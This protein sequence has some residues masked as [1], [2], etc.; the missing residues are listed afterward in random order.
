MAIGERYINVFPYWRHSAHTHTGWHSCGRCSNALSLQGNAFDCNPS[1]PTTVSSLPTAGADEVRPA[2]PQIGGCHRTG[3]ALKRLFVALLLAR[4]RSALV[5]RL[6]MRS[7]ASGFAAHLVQ[8]DKSIPHAAPLRLLAA[9][10][11][12]AYPLRN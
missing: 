6:G 3:N 1:Q 4:R 8:I 11:A 2:R 5:A 10:Y 12:L 7:N 9:A